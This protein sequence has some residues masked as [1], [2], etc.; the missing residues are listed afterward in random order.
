MPE[1]AASISAPWKAKKNI[2]IF[3]G[4]LRTELRSTKAESPI[5][6]QLSPMYLRYEGVRRDIPTAGRTS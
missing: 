3:L 6:S 1:A 5:N 4:G 2:D